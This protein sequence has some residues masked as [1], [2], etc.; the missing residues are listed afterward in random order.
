MILFLSS[1]L[2]FVVSLLLTLAARS[3]P[4]TAPTSAA[5]TSRTRTRTRR[6][7]P[8]RST[9]SQIVKESLLN[10]YAI[11]FAEKETNF[12]GNNVFFLNCETEKLFCWH[13]NTF[14]ITQKICMMTASIMLAKYVRRTISK[15]GLSKK[16]FF[17]LFAPSVSILRLSNW[18]V[19]SW[20]TPPTWIPGSRGEASVTSISFPSMSSADKTFPA[21]VD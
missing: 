5:P 8:T 1:A 7:A 11:E 6:I 14:E 16:S 2:A 21:F 20:T 9:R 12:F 15:E 4:K 18:P 17:Q 19:P 10:W 3:S 13:K